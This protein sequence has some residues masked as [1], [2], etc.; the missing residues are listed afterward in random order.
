[1]LLAISGKFPGDYVD[2]RYTTDVAEGAPNHF[3]QVSSTLSSNLGRMPV[4]SSEAGDVGQS[5]A[6]NFYIASECGLMGSNHFEGAQIIAIQEHVKE[7]STAFRKLVPYGAEPTEAGM[8]AWFDG[9]AD[10]R[11]P[12]PADGSKRGE[13]NINWYIGRIEAVVG[14]GG[15]AVG[16]KI[17]L[18]DVL[19]YNVFAEFLEDAQAAGGLAQFK[20]EP[21]AS[22]ARTDKALE[23][24]PKISAICAAVKANENVAKWLA[25]RGTQRF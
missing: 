6:I 14:E 9:G 3:G 8:N 18:A 22:K 20:R 16:S 4:C 21:F 13:R 24:A 11:S 7:M 17:S 15:F 19:L 23:A 25:M 1:M 5:A 2:G 12:A 10:D